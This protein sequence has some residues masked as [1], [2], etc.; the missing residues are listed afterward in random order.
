MMFFFAKYQKSS[1]DNNNLT[2]LNAC[3]IAC[4]N[5]SYFYTRRNKKNMTL[6]T[7]ILWNE[8]LF[9]VIHGMY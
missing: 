2:I 9:F 4:K 6:K 7:I 3:I 8:M 1:S 5:K